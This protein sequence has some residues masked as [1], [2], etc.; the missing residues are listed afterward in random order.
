MEGNVLLYTTSNKLK[1]VKE[2]EEIICNLA[3]SP[4]HGQHDGSSELSEKH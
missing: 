1:F 2:F 3:C 4:V